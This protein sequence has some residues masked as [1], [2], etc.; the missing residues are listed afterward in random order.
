ME[1]F[2]AKG[3]GTTGANSTAILEGV[4]GRIITG[5]VKPSA[6]IPSAPGKIGD[7]EKKLTDYALDCIT[8]SNKS[9]DA[10]LD[11]SFE[12]IRERFEEIVRGLGLLWNPYQKMLKVYYNALKEGYGHAGVPE[13]IMAKV[14]AEAIPNGVYIPPTQAINVNAYGNID[15]SSIYK[16][17]QRL[18]ELTEEQIAVIGG[19]VGAGPI[20]VGTTTRRGG[21]DATGA[22]IAR[23]LK[24]PYIVYTDTPGIS[25][26]D[27]SEIKNVF[28]PLFYEKLTYQEV[29][30]AAIVGNTYVVNAAALDPIEQMDDGNGQRSMEIRHYKDSDT[31]GT[32]LFRERPL[33]KNELG[34]IITGKPYHLI[35]IIKHG[36]DP[37]VGFNYAVSEAFAKNRVPI[38]HHFDETNSIS[39]TTDR[40]DTNQAVKMAIHKAL[41]DIETRLKPVQIEL[42]EHGKKNGVSIIGQGL[43]KRGG[44]LQ[45]RIGEVLRNL[46]IP[47]NPFSF[48]GITY[49]T[50]VSEEKFENAVRALHEAVIIG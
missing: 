27:T 29:R 45:K 2:V 14:L 13:Q 50:L 43:A 20:G 35:R 18:A 3:G 4:Y 21:S 31:Q 11:R 5:E 1:R 19:F 36:S 32:I 6:L 24:L 41:R 38:H 44:E 12:P 26:V 48:S 46:R 16:A 33:R 7:E 17:R 8:A 28:N 9:D 22:Y 42:D 10:E 47:A 39:V 23:A 15:N 30:E 25:S 40:D 49:T 37:E 34:S